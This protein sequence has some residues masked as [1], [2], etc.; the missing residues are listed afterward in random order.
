MICKMIGGMRLGVR[1]GVEHQMGWG[2][3][4]SSGN[5][6][7][8]HFLPFLTFM[9]LTASAVQY[10]VCMLRTTSMFVTPL[11]VFLNMYFS[12]TG[13]CSSCISI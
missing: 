3:G 4:R 5:M 12:Q 13:F 8:A 10:Q 6:A 11:F 1:T 7:T 9:Y 2:G